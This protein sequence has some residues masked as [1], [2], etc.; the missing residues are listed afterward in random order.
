MS[1]PRIPPRPAREWDRTVMDAIDQMTPPPGSIYARRREERGGA[2]GVNALALL[3]RHPALAKGF[4]TF[5]RHLLYESGLDERTRELV[6]LRVARLCRSPYEWA[7]HVLV[8]EQLG[9]SPAEIDRVLAGPEADGWTPLEAAVL[10]AA[11]QLIDHADVDDDTWAVLA[12]ALDHA[13]L[14]DLIFTVGGYATLAMAF[15][16]SRLPLDP[17][18]RGFPEGAV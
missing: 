8:A 14:L 16:A 10:R 1:E 18:L 2:G 12:A 17:D 9:M 6:V 3:A 7:Q 4:M 5:N 11:D 15:N 13:G